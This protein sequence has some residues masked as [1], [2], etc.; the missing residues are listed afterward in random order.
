M[1]KSDTIWTPTFALL[2][3]AQLLGYAQHAILTPTIPL[4]INELGGSPFMVGVVLACFAVTSVAVR[5]IVGHWVDRWDEAKVMISGLLFLGTS[6]LLCLI[7]LIGATMLGNGLRGIGWAGLNAGGYSLL[8]SSAPAAKRG[9]ASG[10]YSGVQ[11]SATILFAPI[12][13]WVIYAP[14]GGFK[15]AFGLAVLFAFVGAAVGAIISRRTSIRRADPIGENGSWWRELFNLI[16]RDVF[17]P[18]LMLFALNISFP[19]AS[20]FLVLYAHEIGI[21]KFGTYF[22]VSG[23][24]SLLARPLLGHVSD[25]IGRHRSLAAERT[26][27]VKSALGGVNYSI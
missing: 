25:R 13:L 16:D 6:I 20:S 26:R 3:L 27:S 24:T 1:T 15:V 12:A 2:C 23:A 4:Y 21:E 19:A 9:E 17:L 10:Y 22:V 8:A 18:S 14:F 5:P 7:P 11:G